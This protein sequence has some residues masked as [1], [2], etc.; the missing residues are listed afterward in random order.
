MKLLITQ[1]FNLLF[2]SSSV[3]IFSSVPCSQTPS[4]CFSLN[5]RDQVSH[6]YKTKA[7]LQFLWCILAFIFLDNRRQKILISRVA[8]IPKCTVL[9]ISSLIK[10]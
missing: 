2:H 6:P 5:K 10:F 9:L 1:F 3:Q 8:N 7:E 4:V